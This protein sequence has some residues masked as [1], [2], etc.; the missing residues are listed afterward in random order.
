MRFSEVK[1][2][3]PRPELVPNSAAP[4]LFYAPS[5]FS[6]LNGEDPFLPR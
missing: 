2:F 5:L 6:L 3:A 4:K 1:R